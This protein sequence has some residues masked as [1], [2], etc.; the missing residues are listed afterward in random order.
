MK[1]SKLIF[2]FIIVFSCKDETKPELIKKDYKLEGNKTELSFEAYINTLDNIKLPF[3]Y[4]FSNSKYSERFNKAGFKKYKHIWT[5]KPL[6]IL[7]KNDDAIVIADLAI[8]DYGLVPFITSF[9]FDGNK[10]D[11]LSPYKKSGM[12]MGYEAIEFLIIN[13]NRTI[14]VI[15]SIR[16]W[17][18]NIDKTD[19][20][21]NSLTITSDTVIYTIKENGKIVK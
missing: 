17:K 13:K 16:K 4:S 6:G 15:D 18:L 14:T 12:D 9:D 2:L 11:S 3:K 19:I 5:T 21:E 10:I 20:I 8:G 1:I 7:Y